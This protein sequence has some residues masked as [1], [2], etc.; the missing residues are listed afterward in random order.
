[1]NEYR[2]FEFIPRIR[3]PYINYVIDYVINEKEGYLYF[4][5]Y[6][7]IDDSELPR[8][9]FFNT[10][11]R[12]ETNEISEDKFYEIEI[13]KREKY[14]STSKYCEVEEDDGSIGN[15]CLFPTHKQKIYFKV[16]REFNDYTSCSNAGFEYFRKVK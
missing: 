7:Y 3:T 11:I 5:G 16:I 8:R 14:D 10:Y 15:I 12:S 13:Y 6:Y 4:D 2:Y 9:A 1:M